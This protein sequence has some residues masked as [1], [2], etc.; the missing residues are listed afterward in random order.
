MIAELSF[1][2]KKKEK[3]DLLLS[4]QNKYIPQTLGR[5]SFNQHPA[6]ADSFQFQYLQGRWFLFV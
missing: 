6:L 2:K 3:V 5:Y 1:K 4:V